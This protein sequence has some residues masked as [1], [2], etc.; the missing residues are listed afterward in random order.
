MTWKVIRC[1]L[2]TGR[3]TLD[4]VDDPAEI[5]RQLQACA[6]GKTLGRYRHPVGQLAFK[7]A[8]DKIVARYYDR[9]GIDVEFA[10]A[11]RMN[12]PST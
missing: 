5:C 10:V 9:Y 3:P 2:V 6:D 1:R 12:A 4:G 8:S 11:K 7:I